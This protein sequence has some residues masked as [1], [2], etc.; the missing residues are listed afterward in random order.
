[1][2][3]EMFRKLLDYAQV[4]DNIGVL[5][6]GVPNREV[7]R[8]FIVTAPNTVKTHMAFTAKVYILSQKEG[9]RARPFQS[10][11]RPQFFFRVQNVTGTVILDNEESLAMPGENITIKVQ[12]VEKTVVEVGLRFV[13]REGKLT[14]GAGVIIALG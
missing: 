13:M 1:M 8:G 12:L 14:I 2:G 9:G 6:K 10:G 4:G 5:L 11:Y 3:L 7:Y